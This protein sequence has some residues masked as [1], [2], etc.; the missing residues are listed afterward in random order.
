MPATQPNLAHAT[1]L[2]DELLDALRG[3]R[4]SAERREARERILQAVLHDPA[5]LARALSG[6]DGAPVRRLASRKVSAL[7][8]SKLNKRQPPAPPAAST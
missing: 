3:P 6:P 4:R 1:R 7:I 8:S 5:W 2:R